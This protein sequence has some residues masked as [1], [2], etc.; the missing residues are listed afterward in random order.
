MQNRPVELITTDT[1]RRYV[2]TY[3]R[4]RGRQIS[5]QTNLCSEFSFMACD[6]GVTDKCNFSCIYCFI[7]SNDKPGE[8]MK[9][10]S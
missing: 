4:S 5:S 1:L 2:M 6:L 3:L 10:Y 9:K 8:G 7:H